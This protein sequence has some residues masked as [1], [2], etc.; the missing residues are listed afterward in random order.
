MKPVVQEE[1]TG[2]AIACAAAIAGITYQ[3]TKKI[4]NGIGIYAQDS[5]LCSE[6][7]YIRKLLGIL[8]IK[9]GDKEIPFSGWDK[10]PDCALLSIKWHEVDEKAYWHWVV[11]TRGTEG[12][13]VLD[14]KKTLK[15]N[16]R[17]DFGR[18]NPKWYIEVFA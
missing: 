16:K 9:T 11:F 2:C 3:E 17:T 6:T 10:L 18:M 7:S 1:T 5:A 13:Y 8:G 15:S 14:S 4:A 12:S